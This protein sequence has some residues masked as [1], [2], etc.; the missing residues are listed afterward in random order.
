MDLIVYINLTIIVKVNLRF[1]SFSFI[2]CVVFSSTYI[3]G[4]K[5]YIHRVDKLLSI[6]G[7]SLI[8]SKVLTVNK[9]I[10]IS[11]EK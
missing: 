7:I 1:Q 8:T 3:F 2:I 9:K 10:W 4:I 5:E 11:E 6:I